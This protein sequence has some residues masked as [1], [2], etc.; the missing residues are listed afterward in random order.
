MFDELCGDQIVLPHLEDWLDRSHHF[1][2]IK[3]ILFI[4]KIKEMYALQFQLE[5]RRLYIENL[6]DVSS[7]IT[8]SQLWYLAHV[9]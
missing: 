1:Y 8:D 6:V 2:K 5:S 3:L 4:T 7:I 9:Y